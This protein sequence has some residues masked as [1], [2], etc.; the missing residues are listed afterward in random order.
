M[1]LP[2]NT[3]KENMKKNMGTIDKAVRLIIAAVIVILFLT[4]VVTG[5][6][7]YVLLALAAIFVLTSLISFCPLYALFNI[8]SCAVKENKTKGVN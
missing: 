4:N 7:A 6:L 5:V 3:K 8:N 2:L 1:K